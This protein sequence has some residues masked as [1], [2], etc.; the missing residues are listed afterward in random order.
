VPKIPSMNIMDLTRAM[1]PNCTVETIGIR[2]GEK[3]H[4]VLISEDEVRQTLELDDMF[5]VRPAHPWWKTE[6][7]VSGRPLP[8]GFRYASNSNNQWLTIAEL[9]KMIGELHE[10]H[11]GVS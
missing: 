8:E 10:E 5:V 9:K 4:E 6:N 2:P 7:W 1:A 3:L 11:S